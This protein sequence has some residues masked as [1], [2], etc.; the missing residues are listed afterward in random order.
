MSSVP[1]STMN[2][3]GVLQ[4]RAQRAPAA[5]GTEHVGESLDATGEEEQPQELLPI[6]S[7]VCPSW[8]PP[9]HPCPL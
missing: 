9:P 4:D 7:P 8:H 1:G 6:T 2:F 5:D 3:P